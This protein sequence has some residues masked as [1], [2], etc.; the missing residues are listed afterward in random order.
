MKKY[1]LNSN[2]YNYSLVN[3]IFLNFIML[4]FYTY[5]IKWEFV[6]LGDINHV[7]SPQ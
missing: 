5:F 3:F 6:Q 4:I 2:M 7:Y 1:I